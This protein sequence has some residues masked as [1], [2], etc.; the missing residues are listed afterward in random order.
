MQLCWI[1]FTLQNYFG[2]FDM[3]SKISTKDSRILVLHTESS[4]RTSRN[5]IINL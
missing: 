4:T 5:K 1:Q 2:L 3:I